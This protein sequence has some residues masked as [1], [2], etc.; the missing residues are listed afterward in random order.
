MI[1]AM[2]PLRANAWVTGGLFAAIIV[3]A[4][5]GNVLHDQGLVAD[6]PRSQS[7][8][9]ALFFG[10]FLLFGLSAIPLMVRLVLAGHQRMGNANQPII[11]TMLAHERFIVLAVWALIG[12]GLALAVP[13]AIRDGFF[14]PSPTAEIAAPTS[15]GTL[16]ARPGMTVEEIR[17]RSSLQL[18]GGKTVFAD[19]TLFTFEIA[20][21]TISFPRCRYYFMTYA[22]GDNTRIGMMSIGTSSRV[23][24]RA[25]LEMADSVLRERLA[26]D[27]WLAGHEVYRT[28]QD[29]TLHGGA[30]EGPGGHTWRQG[31]TLLTI[32]RRRMDDAK[33]NEAAD[34]GEWIQFLDLSQFS[35]WSL[36]ERFVFQ[37]PRR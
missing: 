34:A 10:L 9:K 7:I 33:P 35:E 5:I 4:A 21:S 2:F 19:G 17:R 18:N 1:P 37:P 23:M 27:G 26:S 15:R 20:D 8:A 3:F 22:R 16:V 14:E 32:Q 25:E 31:D 29:R 12:L 36:R 13:A 30:S 11:R 28:E 24:S 6:S